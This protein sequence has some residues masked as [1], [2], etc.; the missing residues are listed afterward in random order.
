MIS[1]AWMKTLRCGNLLKHRTRRQDKT[2]ANTNIGHRVRHLFSVPTPLEKAR[3]W[4][5]KSDGTP[6]GV[7]PVQA[8]ITIPA[9]GAMDRTNGADCERREKDRDLD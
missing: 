9:G 3:A 8:A 5:R 1:G 6:P 2:P 7:E 4:H